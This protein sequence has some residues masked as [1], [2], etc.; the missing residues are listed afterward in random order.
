MN[1]F[2]LT[3]FDVTQRSV[4][5]IFPSSG[6][7]YDFFNGDSLELAT[8]SI[9]MDLAPGEYKIYTSEKIAVEGEIITDIEEQITPYLFSFF[10]NPMKPGHSFTALI[11]FQTN[12]QSVTLYSLTGKAVELSFSVELNSL[13]VDLPPE[14]AGGL[15]VLQLATEAKA[16]TQKLV[17]KSNN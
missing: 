14:L 6:T 9:N 12:I 7:W 13:R 4:N 10:P 17:I 3:N 15:Y 5:A 1:A 16:F 8:N 11:P 2:V